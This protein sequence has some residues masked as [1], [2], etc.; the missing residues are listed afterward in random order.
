MTSDSLSR[1]AKSQA[2]LWVYGFACGVF[3]VI[4]L[5]LPGTGLDTFRRHWSVQYRLPALAVVSLA[6]ACYVWVLDRAGRFSTPEYWFQGQAIWHV[7]GA[8]SLGYMA[9]YYRSE[10]PRRLNGP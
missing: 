10:R 2:P 1:S 3:S 4:T 7:L 6:V 9:L 8:A 5:V